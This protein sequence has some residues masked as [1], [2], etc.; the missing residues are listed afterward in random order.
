MT[1]T[2]N[3]NRYEDEEIYSQQVTPT[4]AK[5]VQTKGPNLSRAK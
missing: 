4:N 5:A 1:N 2:D 3:A